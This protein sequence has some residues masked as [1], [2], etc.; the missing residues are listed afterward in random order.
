MVL[1]YKQKRYKGTRIQTETGYVYQDTNRNGIW[2]LG[3]KQKRDK[4]TRLQAETV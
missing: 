1:A 3:Y 4:G 2:V